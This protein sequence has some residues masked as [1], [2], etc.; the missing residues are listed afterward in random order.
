MD[1]EILAQ[2]RKKFRELSE[3]FDGFIT[4]ILDDW[5]G[6]RFIY[7][8]EQASC[9]RYGC[10]RCPLY[11]LLVNEKDGLFSA[12]LLPASADDKLLF[13]PQ[14]FL[15]CKSFSEYQ[16]CYS[17]FLVQKCFTRKEMSEELNLVSEMR[18]M[19]SRNGSLRRM[20]TKLKKGVICKALRLANPEQKKL[21]RA[22]LMLRPDFFGT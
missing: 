21:I 15:N 13:G 22:Y 6:Y 4:V 12:G 18:V 8:V 11:R 17:N 1:P 2:A 16:D 5:R 20:E 10:T 7:D 14:N 9:C 3:Q 19:Y